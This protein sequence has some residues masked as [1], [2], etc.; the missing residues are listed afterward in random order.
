MPQRRAIDNLAPGAAAQAAPASDDDSAPTRPTV[1]IG[2]PVYNG[3]RYIRQS[4]DALLAQEFTDFELIVSDNASTDDTGEIVSACAA[5]DTRVRYHRNEENLGGIGNFNR[6][7]EL[8]RGKYFL[9]ASCHDLWAP[10]FLALCVAQMERDESIVLCCTRSTWI[11]EAGQTIRRLGGELDTRGLSPARR[12]RR[13]LRRHQPYQIYGLHRFDALQKVLPYRKTL[14]PDNLILV[15]LAFLGSFALVAE[16]LFHMRKLGDFGSWQDYFRKLN[17]RLTPLSGPAMC[18]RYVRDHLAIVRRYE[19]R[20][21]VRLSL[22]L[23]TIACMTLRSWPVFAA[24][25]LEGLFPRGIP[26]LRRKLRRQR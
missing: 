18:R 25:V 13:V 24:I 12:Y 3:A 5:A 15:E 6:V 7:C 2:M 1:S 19:Q 9:W 23:Y 16:E 20:F 4:L 14:G 22:R 10:G 11:D 8:A 26:W 21:L 17:M